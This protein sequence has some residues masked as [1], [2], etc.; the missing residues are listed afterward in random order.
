MAG[1]RW[2]QVVLGAGA[3]VVLGLVVLLLAGVEPSLTGF[4][5]FPKNVTVSITPSSDAE[6]TRFAFD[7]VI[8]IGESVNISIELVNT[9]ST[10][11]DSSF[12]AQVYD[13][14][15]TLLYTY[16]GPSATLQPGVI[17]ARDMKHTPHETGTYIIRVRAEMGSSVLQSARFLVVEEEPEQV[18]P[19]P[20][21]ITRTRV[22]YVYPPPAP[23]TPPP[24][25]SWLVD[26]PRTV[27]LTQGSTA[28]VPIRI[29]NTGEAV[30]RNIQLALRSSGNLTVDF[31][32]KI[33]FGV[34]TGEVRNF[35]LTVSVPEDLRGE[36]EISYRILSD[37]LGQ[38]GDITVHV[39]P[40]V[41]IKQLEQ[42]I[43]V[44]ERLADDLEQEIAEEE[45]AGLDVTGPRESLEAVREAILDA[46]TA[47]DERN[48][49]TVQARIGTARDRI[50]EA[51]QKLFKLRSEALTV[52]APLIR[53]LY[54]LILGAI[55]V[56]VLMVGA[57]YYMKEKHEERPKLLRRREEEEA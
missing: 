16:P 4:L 5:T 14:N 48:L 43:A 10:A 27:N 2:Q 22:R 15:N 12:E 29:E 45:A 20:I 38:D 56:A 44:L 24:T 50:G 25:R 37:R 52:T 28:T 53:P 36:Q 32:P 6:I 40:A 31:D 33:L 23:E 55:L 51:Y 19:E 9:G 54:L 21:V 8:T 11:L 57:Y 42:E 30:L 1:V 3:V 13:I 46:R 18:E 39:V 49:E 47:I 7:R 26:A 35:M 41:T 17:M 34:G